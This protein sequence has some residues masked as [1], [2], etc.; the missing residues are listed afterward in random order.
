V[1]GL[2]LA[3]CAID[4]ETFQLPELKRT[5]FTFTRPDW[6]SQVKND[7][8]LRP[9][10][11]QDLVGPDG[12]CAGDPVPA[13]GEGQAGSQ[14]LNFTAGP[15]AQRPPGAGPSVPGA[16]PP[17]PQPAARGVG[18]GMTECEVIGTIGHTDQ[19]E[20]STNERGQRSLVL[21]YVQGIRPGIYRF[22]GGHLVSI[23]RGSE[24]PPPPPK[25]NK[26]TA[27]KPPK[28]PANS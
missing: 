24:P 4:S 10:T 18:L 22:A 28:K 2:S 14:A 16:P 17:P 11:A 1:L 8:K 25:P 7:M 5:E 13:P 12:R 19:I 9:V 21:T 26:K 23:E 3:S 20:L 6:T 15:E 27:K